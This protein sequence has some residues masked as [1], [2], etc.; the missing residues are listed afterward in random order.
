MTQH[1]LNLGRTQFGDAANA[2]QLM[3]M[4]EAHQLLQG[5]GTQ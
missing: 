2:G 1:H 5:M 4:E 3:S